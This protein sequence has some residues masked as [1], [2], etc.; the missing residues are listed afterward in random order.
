MAREVKTVDISGMPEVLRLAQEVSASGEARVLR[1]AD[2]DLAVLTPAKPTPRRLRRRKTGVLTKDDALFN[3]IG[4]AKGLPD[5]VTDVS[6][7]KYKYLA[8]AYAA[9]AI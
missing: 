4:L 8:D 9:D 6:S 7:N 5:G 3:I 1:R 2:E